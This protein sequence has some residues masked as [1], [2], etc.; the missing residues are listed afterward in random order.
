MSTWSKLVLSVFRGSRFEVRGSMLAAPHRGVSVLQSGGLHLVWRL[1]RCLTTNSDD[2]PF[3]RYVDQL[4]RSCAL[5][6]DSRYVCPAV[7]DFLLRAGVQTTK[8]PFLH[9]L[10]VFND[11]AEPC[12]PS[13]TPHTSMGR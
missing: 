10:C 4:L 6:Q 12:V 11:P 1:R 2:D 9:R 5:L 8:T 3:R 13:R 7:G